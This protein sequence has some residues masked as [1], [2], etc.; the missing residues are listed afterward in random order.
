MK[1]KFLRNIKHGIHN[2]IEWFPIIW[3]DAQWDQSYL[4]NIM[5]KKL[6]L[7]E[8]YFKNDTLIVESE[9]N[10]IVENIRNC[11]ESLDK[12]EQ[13]YFNDFVENFKHYREWWD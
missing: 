7:M 2:L 9:A 5:I 1:I 11:K 8:N 10:H 13:E 3:D 4:L 12:L 6:S